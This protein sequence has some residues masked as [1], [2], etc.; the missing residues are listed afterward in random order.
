MGYLAVFLTAF[1]AAVIATPIARR[2]AERVGALDRPTASRKIH[3]RPMPLFGGLAVLFGLTA[4]IAV[5]LAAGWLPDAQIKYKY[6]IG[7]LLAAGLLVAG[8]TL[9]DR[10][11]FKPSRQFIWP[12]LAAL[13]I[14]ASGIGIKYVTNP[15]GGQFYLDRWQTTVLWWEGIPY[16]LTLLADIFSF[17]WLLGI[18]YTTKFLD[19]LDGLVSGIAVI[20]GLVIAAVSLMKE[21]SQPGTALLALAVAGAFLGF[22]MFNFH[23]ARI[24]LGEGGSTLAGFLLATLA[25]ISGGKIATTLLILALPLFDA[26]YVIVR[27]LAGRRSP[28]FGDRSHLH[29]GLLDLGLTQ[30]QAVLIYWFIAAACG[31]AT[32]FLKGWQKVVALGAVGSLLVALVAAVLWVR[33]AHRPI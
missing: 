16:R 33:R 23:P 30:R 12:V 7:L 21:V 11:S 14:I 8:G 20:G 17:C 10:F 6:V 18:T 2:L 25:I 13:V 24:F 15:F 26:A 27:R 28:F 3:V 29:F 4:A 31:M 5:A 9:D 22:L 32:L 19:G 1:A